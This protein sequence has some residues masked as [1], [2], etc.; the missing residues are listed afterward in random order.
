MVDRRQIMTGG[1]LGSVLGA[2]GAEAAGAAPQ[3]GVSDQTL[4]RGVDRVVRALDRLRESVDAQRAFPEIAAI[5]DV[6]KTYMRANAKVPDFLEVGIDVWYNVH[7]WHVRWSQPMTVG[8]DGVGR[9]TLALG[10]TILILRADAP[11]A[12]IGLPY[13]NRW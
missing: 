4:D 1:V 7:D 3:S 5:R 8:R 9:L 12:F 13:D 10:G 2:L 11:P 6:Q